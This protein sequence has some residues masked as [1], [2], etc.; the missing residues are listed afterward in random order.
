MSKFFS[1]RFF[2]DEIRVL[3]KAILFGRLVNS[4][5][6]F[7]KFRFQFGE[8]IGLQVKM[9]RK[10]F[11]SINII[12]GEWLRGFKVFQNKGDSYERIAAMAVL[13]SYG[14]KCRCFACVCCG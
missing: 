10:I 1:S 6:V 14:S 8:S 13:R 11:V 3:K 9:H 2:F 5:E 7:V 12:F 4:R